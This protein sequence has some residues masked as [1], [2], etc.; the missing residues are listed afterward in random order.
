M[1]LTPNVVA[2]LAMLAAVGAFSL[3]DAG[4]KVLVGHYPA[5]Q[6]AALRGAASLP[7]VLAWALATVGPRALVH[8]RWP[9]HLLRGVLSVA[10]MVG[11]AYGLRSLP[12]STAY[13]LFFIAPLLVT[14]L[15]VP[16]LGERV[17]PRRWSAILV[18]LLGVLVVMR[19]T[20]EGLF[21]LGAL[22]VLLAAA[23]YSVSAIA[24]RVLGRTDSTQAMVV[25]MVT[26]L[27]I[28]A[29]I[30]AAP[31]WVQVRA[32]HWLLIAGI[33]V[34][35]ALGQYGI[36]E[37]FRRGEASVIAPLEYTALAWG[38][39]LDLALWGVLPD[40]ITWLGAAIIVASGLYLL[41]RERA[42]AQAEHP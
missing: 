30:L 38:V 24:V 14:A 18:G 2:A 9:L 1:P 33:G 36:T 29:G 20:G 39:A 42:H 10:M 37:A 25:W 21:T 41:R 3:M 13:T 34:T 22:A 11:F 32:E 19:P 7:L 27:A 28:G 6:V 12:L 15:S 4:L 5:I 17:G 26:M 16:V 31:V 23:C 40:A 35:G 8:V